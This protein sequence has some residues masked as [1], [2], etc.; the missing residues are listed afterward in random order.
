MIEIFWLY[1]PWLTSGILF[2]A[3]T[4]ATSHVVLFK[5]DSRAALGWVGLIWFAP[6]AGVLFYLLFGINR[7]QR[8]ARRLRRKHR[9]PLKEDETKQKG[10]APK[11]GLA[12][13]RLLVGSLTER[14]ILEGNR[15]IPYFTGESAYTEMLKAMESAQ[16]SIALSTY[17][18]D[19]D[20]SGRMFAQALADAVKRGIEVRVLID[21]IG[22]RYSLPSIVGSLRE[23]GVIVALFLPTML[24]WRFTY[25]QLRNHRKILVVDGRIAFTGGMNIREGHDNRSHSPSPI[26]DCHFRIEGPV[27]K[28]LRATFADDWR[29]ATGELLSGTTWFP[30]L[31]AVGH[32]AARGIASGPDDDFE[33][34]RLTY[35]GAIA[36]AQKTIRIV[37]PYFVPDTDLLSALS[38]AALRGVKVDILVPEQN[39]LQ[40]VHWAMMA[41]LDPLLENGCRIWLTPPPFDHTKIFQVDD[42][43]SLIG[44]ANW[45]SRSLRLNFEFDLECY[46]NCLHGELKALID[47]TLAMSRPISRED[48]QHRSLL[49]K[50]R[51]GV[52]RLA[53][54]YL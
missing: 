15:V 50:L 21:D 30:E 35:L 10:S 11:D 53:S 38:V 48:L 12:P 13:L 31:E 34:L 47:K 9:L 26:R 8:K 16:H 39:N 44:S 42:D 52:A 4:W 6:I 29:F 43:W 51:D 54:S 27:V 1:W 32:G 40:L 36:C 46:D 3:A 23:A 37:T 7:I 19:N 24:P 5:R 33:K 22:S 25:A 49:C 28:D 41:Q 2:L 45:D 14:P 17:I 18:F 20:S